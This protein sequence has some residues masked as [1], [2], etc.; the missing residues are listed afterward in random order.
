V[1]I[2]MHYHLEERMETVDRLLDQVEQHGIGR[3][4]LIA[5]LVDPLQV[6][7]IAARFAAIGVKALMSTW[8]R[9]LGLLIYKSTVTADGNF[10]IPGR[11]YRIYDMPDNK[12]VA[13]VMQAHPDKFYGW[14][15]VNPS[16]A[17]P[18]TELERWAG[19]PGWIGV[20]SHPFWHRYPVAM[21]DDVAAYCS[22]RGLPLLVH[23]GGD[24]ERGDYRYLPERH[25]HLKVIYPHA[26]VPFYRQVWEFAKSRDGVFVDL[27]S[28]VYVTEPVRLGAVRALGAEKCLHGTDGPYSH[29]TQGGM[30]KDILRLPLSDTDKERIL[31]GNFREMM[32]A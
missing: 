31:G 12:S 29:A 13:R 18:F 1:I 14:I 6:V 27:S 19:Q 17:D 25:P 24:R 30:L 26:G 3:V 9:R 23:L 10:W 4:A 32:A 8:R 20:K 11:T 28:P 5:T 21:L 7:G 16:A 2:D 22:E 15:F